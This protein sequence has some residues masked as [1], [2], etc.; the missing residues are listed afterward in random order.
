MRT[1][2]GAATCIFLLLTSAAA[3]QTAA[4]DHPAR[5]TFYP[6]LFQLPIFGATV[7]IPPAQEG[8]GTGGA[9]GSGSTDVSINAAYMGAVEVTA[10]RLFGEVDFLWTKPSASHET[11]RVDVRTDI[12]L[13]TMK[14]G[15]RIYKGLMATS[16]ARR[17]SLDLA[18]T[19]QL[20]ELGVT[21]TGD[22]TK[23]LWDPFVGAQ[24]R[25]EMK[26]RLVIDVAI[27][28]GG[29]NVGTDSDLR[30]AARAG[31]IIVNHLVIRGGYDVL[32]FEWTADT[33]SVS[34]VQR[35]LKT[36]QTLHGPEFGVGIV[37]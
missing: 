22:T 19:L 24:W 11:P 20:P 10:N 36:T 23:V 34:G 28:Y 21:L 4:E 32:R 5:I 1:R 15:Y 29:F 37:F 25:S 33:A 12:W 9:G 2:I 7:S 26:K 35:T 3:A 13:V 8:G 18:A 31:W 30:I 14:G 17:L 16:G 6:I 27:E